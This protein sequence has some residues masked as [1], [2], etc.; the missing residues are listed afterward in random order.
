MTRRPRTAAAP[1]G[2]VLALRDGREWAPTAPASGWT[3]ATALAAAFD[4][5]GG[6]RRA[7]KEAYRAIVSAVPGLS[8]ASAEARLRGDDPSSRLFPLAARRSA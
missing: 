3:T 5:S 8:R 4:F 2:I 7:T 1:R 6:D